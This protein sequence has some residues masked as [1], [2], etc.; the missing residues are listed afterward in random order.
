VGGLAFFGL[1]KLLNQQLCPAGQRMGKRVVR[2]RGF[3]HQRAKRANRPD[4]AVRAEQIFTSKEEAESHGLEL[5]KA[6]V[7]ERTLR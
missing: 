7:D 4:K 1:Q 2:A 5:A 3:L 6:W